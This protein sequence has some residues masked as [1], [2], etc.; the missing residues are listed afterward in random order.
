[1]QDAPR[2][3]GP[4]FQAVRRPASRGG[5]P[6]A[7]RRDSPPQVEVGRRPLGGGGG[8]GGGGHWRRGSGRGDGG[9]GRSGGSV[10]GGGGPGGAIWGGERGGGGQAPVT[11]PC[12]PSGVRAR[13]R[14]RARVTELV[15]PVLV[16]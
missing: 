9:G 16:L 11:S 12:P 1:M 15:E 2:T 4:W 14:V 6:L 8:G 5:R 3:G 13:A 10:G 7:F